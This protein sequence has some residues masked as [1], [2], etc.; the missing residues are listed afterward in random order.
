MM[1][2]QVAPAQLFYDFCLDD[3]QTVITAR[4]SQSRLTL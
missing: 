2:C 4:F 1:G 3:H